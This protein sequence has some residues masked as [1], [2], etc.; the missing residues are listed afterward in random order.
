MSERGSACLPSICSGDMYWNVPTTGPCA[1]R[2]WLPGGVAHG[3][4]ETGERAR[5]ATEASPR[6][7][8]ISLAP[9]LVSICCQ[10][11]NRDGYTAAMGLLH[12]SHMSTPI[13]GPAHRQW[14]LCQS[15]C[16]V[17]P[18]QVLHDQIVGAVLMA[19]I[20]K[21]ADVGMADGR[22]GARFRSKRCRASAFSD[23]CEGRIFTATIRSRRVSRARY[24]SPIPPAPRGD[25]IS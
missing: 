2:G 13:A 7:K 6:P 1:V 11:L 19:D 3:D 17:S 5:H 24:T 9:V 18:F 20:V 10:A 15:L 21:R 25:W 8:S 14:P 12:P 22:N 23:R 16:Q 4:R